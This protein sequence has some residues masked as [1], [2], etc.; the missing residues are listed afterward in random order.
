MAEIGRR[1][2]EKAWLTVR[3]T[4]VTSRSITSLLCLLGASM[5]AVAFEM[6]TGVSRWWGK[7]KKK[8]KKKK[9]GLLSE[10]L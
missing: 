4:F 6:Q 1:E 9:W 2:K 8:K 5:F 3:A 10:L 7:K